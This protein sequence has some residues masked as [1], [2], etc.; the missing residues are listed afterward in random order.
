MS[1][2]TLE[3]DK[4]K[5]RAKDGPGAETD[6]K[7]REEYGEETDEL[8]D[9]VPQGG[10]MSLLAHL[11]EL[12]SL[13]TFC[14]VC[15]L[16]GVAL[17][18]SQAEWFTNL[19]LS[20]GE[21]FSF[22]YIAPAELM[23]TYVRISLVGGVVIIIPVIIYHIWR[24]LQPGLKRAEQMGFNLIIT[25]GLL[26]FCLG[27]LFA[28]T[29]VLPIL[30]GFFARLNTSGTVTAMVSVQEYVSYVISTMLIFGVIFE[31]PIVLV[32][33]TGVGL[34]KPKTLQK[35]FK[36]VVLII[37][38]VAA[39]IT[40]PDVTSQVLVAIPLMILFYASIILCKILFR[41][42]LAEQEEDLD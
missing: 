39:V 15:F 27:A 24:F 21:N 8:E 13:L 16:V 18:L 1:R 42:K 3:Q 11:N 9:D 35:N 29:I 32:A 14:A 22:V 34:V 10:R 33:L 37:L 12:R 26:L 19:L 23:M 6:R 20:R 28:F 7:E 38:I 31:T 4:K 25:G 30:L 36:Y 5:T 41:R 2:A 17:C 40:P